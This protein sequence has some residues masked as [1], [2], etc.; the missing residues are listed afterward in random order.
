MK[1]FATAILAALV[2]TMSVVALSQNANASS[3][4]DSYEGRDHDRGDR[5]R[6]SR[7]DHN[8]HDRSDRNRDRDRDHNRDSRRDHNRNDWSDRNDHPDQRYWH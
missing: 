3:Y 5:D 1:R 4:D 7:R 2:G 8:R 6:D